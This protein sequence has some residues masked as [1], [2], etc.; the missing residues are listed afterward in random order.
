MKKILILS[1]DP[2]SIN[3]EIIYKAWKSLSN[4]LKKKVYIVSN[5]NLF[6]NQLKKIGISH[7]AQRVKIFERSKDVNSI[8]IIDF[9]VPYKNSFLVDQKSS[10]RFFKK[11][12]NYAHNLCVKGELKGFINCPIDKK[13]LNRKGVTEYLASKCNVKN[14]S[15]VMLIKNK[16]FSVS[17]VTTHIKVKSIAKN[18]TKKKIVNKVLTVHNWFKA[19]EKKKPKIALLGLNPHN[20]EFSKDS[21]E[22]KII[23]PAIHQLKKMNINVKGPFSSDTFFINDYK[24]YDVAVGMFHDQVITPFKTLFGFDAINITLGL[25]YLRSSPDHGVAKNLIGRNQS[26]CSSL[27]ACINFFD[28]I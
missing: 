15:E 9:A 4:R 5:Y 16:N 17:P 23:N 7:N 21:E 14:Y 8:K 3:S 1:G 10:S 28:K 19:Y 20:S 13:L 18:L 27:L 25:K 22:V 24:E 11:T 26:D 2:N 6:N 12:L